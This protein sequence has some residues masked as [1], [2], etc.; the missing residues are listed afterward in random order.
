MYSQY[1]CIKAAQCL[2]LPAGHHAGRRRLL[3]RQSAHRARHGR[4][5]A[6]GGP[7]RAGAHRGR[8]EPRADAQQALPRGRRRPGEHRAQA[9]AGGRCCETIGAVHVCDSSSPDVHG[10]ADRG[11]RRPPGPPSPSTPSAAARS[12]G[13]ILTAHGERPRN[14]TAKEYSRYG[15]TTHKQVYIYGGLDRGPDRAHPQLRHGVGHRRLAADPVP[16]RR[17][18]C[19][20][21]P[22]AARAGGGRDQDHLRQHVHR[23]RSRSP[24]RCSSTRSR[25]TAS[26]P[27][28]RST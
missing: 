8:V 19:R 7:H 17:S 4:D 9:G 28:A 12:A 11:A 22:E 1:R 14:R 13:Q 6:R 27:P 23:A 16:A 20:G 2:V 26:R 5:D 3:L 25:S 15:S 10:R 24:G 21:G 18:G